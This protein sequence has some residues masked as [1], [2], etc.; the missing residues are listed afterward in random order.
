MDSRKGRKN[1]RGATAA[2]IPA[3]L[4]M[5]ATAWAA[6]GASAWA[7]D[8]TA[9]TQG[10]DA[11]NLPA[12]SVTASGPANP[13]LAADGYVAPASVGAT[14]TGAS[15]LETP[16]TVTVITREE[17]DSRRP[18]TV[19]SVLRY[20]PGVQISEDA[21]NRLDSLSARGFAL[22]QYL[23]GLKQLSGTWAVPKTEPYLLE[24]AEVL[25]GPSSVLYGQASPGGILNMVAKRPTAEPLH[26]VEVQTGTGAMMQGAFDL[27]GPLDKEGRVLYRLTGIGRTAET[28][29]DHTKEQRIAIAPSV[30]WKPDDDTSLTVLAGYLHDPKGGIWNLL[31]YSGTLQ[32]NRY[33]KISPSF[34]TGDTG[35][36]SFRR[37]QTQIG[38]EFEH[39]FGKALTVRQN[40]RYTHIDIDY[41]SVQGLNLQADQRTLNRQTYTADER[42]DTFA[43]DNQAE[44]KLETGPLSH[45]LLAG[46]DYQRIGWDNFTRFGTAPTLDIL[47]PNHNQVI[48]LPGVFQNAYQTQSQV[49]AY[50]Q[51]Q[52]RLGGWSLLLAGRED[53]ATTDSENRLINRRTS[54]FNRAFTG[55]V[56]LTYLFDNG[57]APY[58]SY[59]TSFQPVAGTNRQGAAF[60]PTKGKQV[61]VGVKFQPKGFNSFVTASAFD[62]RQSNVTT[63]DPVNP[64]FSVQTGEVRSRGVEL[65]GV[66]S[67][68]DG[69]SVRAS[70]AYLDN[71]ITKDNSGNAG[72]RLNNVPAHIASLW[73]DYTIQELAL[74][75]LGFG[76]GG[77]YVG[78]TYATN[79]NTVKIP[80]YA[81]FDAAVHYDLGQAVPSLQG[82]QLAVNASNIFDKE[83]VSVCSAVGCRWG[84]GRTVYA[85]VRYSW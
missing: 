68:T 24:R 50:L 27:G 59:A 4:A 51:D 15:L 1:R 75:G 62:L 56:G 71:E 83:Y 43:I 31:P 16:Q 44:L 22:D 73:A 23:N 61:E 49:G 33:G 21:D 32:P 79:A 8:S 2:T 77:R 40:A 66:A 17:L 3:V 67:L 10:G 47:A 9:R 82:T 13:A 76:G 12:V 38:Y 69:L 81:V 41:A 25:T 29:T 85:S 84:L 53:W 35:F 45:T 63:P 54:Q 64:N 80:D 72:H 6:A 70:Y 11:L 39:R 55:R 78:S 37:D 65:S 46:L 34:Y 19:R 58:A 52:I 7:Q 28:Q 57:L 36:E 74:K 5:A 18:Q 30:T 48:T 20:A 26:Q 60:E 42:L 14:K